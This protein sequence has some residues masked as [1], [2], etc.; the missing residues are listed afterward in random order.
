M[1][2]QGQQERRYDESRADSSWTG[3]MEKKLRGRDLKRKVFR[4]LRGEDSREAMEVLFQFPARQVINP[5][6]SLFCNTD[7]EIRWRA[8][9][10]MGAVVA[11]LAEAD[12]EMARVVM[13]RMIWQLNDESGGI[14]WGVPEAMGEIM[15]RH[16]GLAREYAH[17]LVS[18]ISADGNLLEHVPLQRG[19]LWGLGRLAQAR[20]E[21]V[22]EAVPHLRPYLSADD[23]T[24]RGLAAWNMG[25]LRVET[26]RSC[27]EALQGDAAEVPLY[28]NWR[29]STYRVGDLAKW[30]LEAM[31]GQAKVG[32]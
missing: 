4:A 11:K 10:A 18:Y 25:L 8:I 9:T 28:L 32:I 1:G 31:D 24:L 17:M 5:L 16:E 2:S 27:L 7:Q 30:A 21:L 14:G 26:T 13:R 6:F 12:M 15:T 20:P 22:Q 3:V 23:D 29:Q 19:V